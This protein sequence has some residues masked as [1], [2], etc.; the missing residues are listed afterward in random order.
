MAVRCAARSCT[1]ET[2][3]PTHVFAGLPV[4]DYGAAHAWYA[5]LF[6]R[7]PDMTP[8]DTEAVWRLTSCCS[9]YVVQ[10]TERAG[11]GLV[12]LAVND[13][14]AHERRLR[15]A[16]IGF[17]VQADGNA[18][19]RVVVRDGDGNTVTFFHDPAESGT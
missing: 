4:A 16:G 18:P 14:D 5:R 3:V 2:V 12:T 8:H 9:V 1:I 15:E 11:R 7:Q 13:L 6:G 10:D 19:R 17:D